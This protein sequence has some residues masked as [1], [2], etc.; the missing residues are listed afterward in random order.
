VLPGRQPCR[1]NTTGSPPR[2]TV[3][4]CARLSKAIT[5]ADGIPVLA[6]ASSLGLSAT[7][8]PFIVYVP[9]LELGPSMATYVPSG[10]NWTF[11]SLAAAAA[12][13]VSGRYCWACLSPASAALRICASSV[14]ILSI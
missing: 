14:S 3:N 11:M 4:V 13:S 8:S 6:L 9:L 2:L 10:F 1:L 5:T 12:A 7:A